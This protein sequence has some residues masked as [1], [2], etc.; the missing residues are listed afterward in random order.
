VLAL[1]LELMAVGETDKPSLL[2][3]A[4]F[5]LRCRRPTRSSRASTA[6]MLAGS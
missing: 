5:G 3:A 2:F 4:P 1:E 6:L